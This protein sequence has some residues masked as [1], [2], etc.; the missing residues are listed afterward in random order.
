L[1]LAPATDRKTV[2]S[3]SDSA[4]VCCHYLAVPPHLLLRLAQLY[5]VKRYGID[6]F[7][8]HFWKFE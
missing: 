1:R 8:R 6:Q 4:G 5:Y 7:D 3:V 2:D